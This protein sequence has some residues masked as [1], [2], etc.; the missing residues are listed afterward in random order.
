M[1]LKKHRQSLR[2]R[3]FT[4]T[5]DE[6]MDLA[7]LHLRIRDH[8]F[9]ET[10]LPPIPDSYGPVG[11]RYRNKDFLHYRRFSTIR[12]R[13]GGPGNGDVEVRETSSDAYRR[14]REGL[15][16]DYRIVPPM[17]WTSVKGAAEFARMLCMMVPEE[18]Q[19]ELGVIGFQGFRSF[20]A[21]VSGPHWDGFEFGGTYVVDRTCDGGS[22]YL[23]DLRQG[24]R[25]V[26]DYQLNPG[27]VLLFHER[28]GRNQPEMFLHGA[29]SLEGEGY[30]D[31]V[32]LQ[33]EA[34]ED[35]TAARHELADLGSIW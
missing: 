33:L 20:N 15:G 24:G 5:S 8:L 25:Q 13:D 4:I 14:I 31:A 18:Y 28:M 27:E 11:T 22:S 26:L 6:E 19:H 16:D 12:A 21:V 3:G 10:V 1:D 23:F 34:P 2:E 29:T 32:V 7:G 17:T 9:N 35:I 30:R